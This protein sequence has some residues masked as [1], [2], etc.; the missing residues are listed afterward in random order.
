MGAITANRKP[1]AFA[2]DWETVPHVGVPG[3]TFIV[4]MRRTGED[5]KEAY[6]GKLP[7]VA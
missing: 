4:T 7:S 6:K 1:R 5:M 3:T 2:P